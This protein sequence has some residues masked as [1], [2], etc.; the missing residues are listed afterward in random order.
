VQGAESKLGVKNTY[1]YT[2]KPEQGHNQH[3]KQVLRTAPMEP[4]EGR[5]RRRSGHDFMF[6]LNLSPGKVSTKH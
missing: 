6:N 5:R 4:S 2:R 3:P 1:V